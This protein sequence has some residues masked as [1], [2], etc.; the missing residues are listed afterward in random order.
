MKRLLTYSNFL[1]TLLE[2][3]EPKDNKLEDLYKGLTVAKKIVNFL[4]K[5][6]Y[7]YQPGKD[8]RIFMSFKTGDFDTIVPKVDLGGTQYSSPQ[9]F[10]C[11]DMNVWK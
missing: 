4:K 8:S 10:Y 2:R 6:K 9:G 7:E 5:H 11:F 1:E 3:V